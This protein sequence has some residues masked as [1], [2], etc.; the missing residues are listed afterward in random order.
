MARLNPVPPRRVALAVAV[1]SSY[2]STEH[3]LL[4][5]TLKWGVLARL[6]AVY[7]VSEVIVYRDP[8]GDWPG[9]ALEA[10]EVL[11]Y[12]LVAPYLR[13]RV[14]PISPRLR[15]AGVLPPLQ[16]R[17]HGVGGP[18]EGECR[19]ALVEP[20]EPPRLDAGLG[21]R[22]PAPWAWRA[23]RAPGPGR[24]IIVCIESLRPLRLRAA[25]PGEVYPGYRVA[26]APGGLREALRQRRGLAVATSRLGRLAGHEVL[27]SLAEEARA[28]GGLVIAF[29]PP[30]R[31]L[32]RVAEEEG[33]RLEDE[34]SYVLNTV[35]RQG[36]LTVRIEEAVAATL[37]L[38]NLHLD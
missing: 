35:P 24:R 38:L 5:R 22:I 26:L 15:Y 36:T 18:R 10:R 4:L 6:A 30:D 7:R 3:G 25:R 2:A 23:P 9:P 33:W 34:A 8:R 20:G 13:R 21:R 16:L 1:P 29:G 14:I 11:E 37:A 12:L 28:M 17:T 32:Q 31:G 27:S 19:E